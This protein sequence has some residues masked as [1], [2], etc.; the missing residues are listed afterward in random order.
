M[1][2][3][4]QKYRFYIDDGGT[5]QK[6]GETREKSVNRSKDLLDRS[7]DDS[8][9]DASYIGGLREGEV[10]ISG[11]Y[12]PDDPGQTL[13]QAAFESD[14]PTSMKLEGDE[15]GDVQIK[16]DGHIEDWSRTHNL[17]ELSVFELTIRTD[18]EITEDQVA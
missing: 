18:G 17:N 16:F 12:A 4:G 14:S 9:T 3:K 1:P 2:E 15:T 5:M 6:V 11:L 13:I 10:T 7:S 8:P